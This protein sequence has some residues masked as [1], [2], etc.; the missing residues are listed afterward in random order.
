MHVKLDAVFYIMAFLIL[1]FDKMTFI[2][3]DIT[4]EF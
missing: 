2:A 3:S 4:V 1:K